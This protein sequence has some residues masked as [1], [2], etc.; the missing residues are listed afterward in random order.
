MEASRQVHTP[1]A[2]LLWMESRY[3]LDRRLGGYSDMISKISLKLVKRGFVSK[4]SDFL[5]SEISVRPLLK[6]ELT[7]NSRF[8]IK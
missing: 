2:L 7:Y 6:S 8:V 4:L 1:A 3:I 5:P